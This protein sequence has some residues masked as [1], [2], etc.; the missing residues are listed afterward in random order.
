MEERYYRKKQKK[1]NNDAQEA[2]EFLNEMRKVFL[3]YL[4]L[5]KKING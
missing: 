1:G 5:I 3:L 2:E 4:L